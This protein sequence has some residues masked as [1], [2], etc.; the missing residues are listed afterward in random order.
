MPVDAFSDINECDEGT[1][2]CSH[3]CVNIEG[4]HSC[5]CKQGYYSL[6]KEDNQTCVR[7][8]SSSPPVWLLFAHGQ[9]IWNVS[10]DGKH[11][12]M[13][14]SGLEKT[15]VLDVDMTVRLLSSLEL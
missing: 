7:N 4:G 13:K 6:S 1:A 8:T 12:E 3:M 11:V 2:R 5:E 10:N 9:S 14:I 15:S